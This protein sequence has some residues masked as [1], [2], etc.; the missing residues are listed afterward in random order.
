MIILSEDE[1]EEISRT[2]G[3]VVAM[4]SEKFSCKNLLENLEENFYE[5]INAL[6]RVYNSL[7]RFWTKAFDYP[8]HITQFVTDE[9]EQ[10]SAINLLIGYLKL[11]GN[12]YLSQVLHSVTHLKRLIQTLIQFCELE[13]DVILYEEYMIQ[14]NFIIF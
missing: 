6:P 13:R 2:S 5:T 4:M 12:T 11:F 3:T 7:G 9:S 14:G 8:F 1:N 10:L